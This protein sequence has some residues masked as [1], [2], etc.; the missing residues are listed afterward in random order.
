MGDRKEVSEPQEHSQTV[1]SEVPVH[2]PIP[3]TVDESPVVTVATTS[4]HQTNETSSTS[5]PCI[6]AARIS[7]KPVD[8]SGSVT[9]QLPVVSNSVPAATSESES[10]LKPGKAAASTSSGTSASSPLTE[11]T[12]SRVQMSDTI[13]DQTTAMKAG[14]A[15]ALTPQLTLVSAP[16]SPPVIPLKILQELKRVLAKSTEERQQFLDNE[17]KATRLLMDRLMTI[18]CK[19]ERKQVTDL[20]KQKIRWVSPISLD[21]YLN[22]V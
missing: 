11:G 21:R 22:L 16:R 3:V 2:I 9:P 1:S 13:T 7:P 19:K 4:K 15:A 8:S 20:W 6:S 18:T 5:N 14:S 17:F 10:I 12:A